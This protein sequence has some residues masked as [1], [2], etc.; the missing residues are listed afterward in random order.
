[1]APRVTTESKQPGRPAE[2][3][4]E[5]SAAWSEEEEWDN[6]MVGAVLYAQPWWRNAPRTSAAQAAS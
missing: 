4:F 1:M 3:E 2:F 6:G 5:R